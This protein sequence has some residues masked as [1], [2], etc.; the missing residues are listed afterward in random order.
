MVELALKAADLDE[1]QQLK[2]QVYQVARAV[3]SQPLDEKE[4]PVAV[5]SVLVTGKRTR[6]SELAA[7]PPAET[8]RWWKFLHG[9]VAPDLR[10]VA[11]LRLFGELDLE[12]TVKVVGGNPAKWRYA[13]RRLLEQ[14]AALREKKEEPS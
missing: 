14:V 9:Q 5:R 12:E 11:Y 8:E 7:L 13:L 1:R 4:D 2:V 6:M 10:E 3:L